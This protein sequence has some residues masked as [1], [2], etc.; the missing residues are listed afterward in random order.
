MTLNPVSVKPLGGTVTSCAAEFGA[1]FRNRR[2]LVTGATG[3]IGRHLCRALLALGAE[4]TGLSRS[5]ET[6]TVPEGVR[7]LAVDLRRFGEVEASLANIPADLIFHLGAQVTARPDR[8]LVLPMFEANAAGT[9]Y[10]LMAA[11]ARGCERFILIGSAEAL[12]TTN[13]LGPS[14]PYGA[15]KLSAEIY[16]QMFYRLYGLPVVCVRP[17]LT[18]G[19]EQEPTKLIPYTILTLLRGENPLLSSGNRVCDAI[20]VDDVVRGLLM[21]A[22]AP[23]SVLGERIDLGSG[24]GITIKELVETIVKFLGSPGSP[25]FGAIPDRLNEATTEADLERTRS[26]LGWTPHWSLEEGLRETV[27][28]CRRYAHS[29]G[30]L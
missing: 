25:V 2:V 24:K 8:E 16:G 21:A 6:S 18:Y 4:V 15:S 10:L 3:F 28:W 12:D 22:V 9:I 29:G 14:S 7:L 20:Y 1:Q 11:L 30:Q 26:L 17:F 5:A 23:V 13:G 27:T 19:P